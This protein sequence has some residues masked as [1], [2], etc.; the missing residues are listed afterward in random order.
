MK[1]SKSNP[2]NSQLLKAD[3]NKTH[4]LS[5]GGWE[6]FRRVPTHTPASGNNNT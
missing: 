6:E 5:P 4:P 1:I 2:P 3:K